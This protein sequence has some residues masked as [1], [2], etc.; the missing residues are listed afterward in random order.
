MAQGS[1]RLFL[2]SPTLNRALRGTGD[3]DAGRHRRQSDRAGERDPRMLGTCA[4]AL[5]LRQKRG[6]PVLPLRRRQAGRNARADSRRTRLTLT[7]SGNRG[8]FHPGPLVGK[9]RPARYPDWTCGPRTQSIPRRFEGGGKA[10]RAG[11][12]VAVDCVGN[13]DAP[14][15]VGRTA[16]FLRRTR[17]ACR[18]CR[19]RGARSPRRRY[20]AVK[21]ASR[22]WPAV[23]NPV[24]ADAA[25]GPLAPL[26]TGEHDAEKPTAAGDRGGVQLAART[27]PFHDQAGYRGLVPRKTVDSSTEGFTE[28][29]SFSGADAVS[30]TQSHRAGQRDSSRDVLPVAAQR[31][32]WRSRGV[33]AA[34][35]LVAI[36]RT[37]P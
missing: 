2:S 31:E 1:P 14:H 26:V 3:K 27:G 4:Q 10:N 13:R 36:K 30:E 24:C 9:S 5:V 28:N 19:G 7:G 20:P 22:L 15:S 23:G 21:E 32:G 11:R 16:P 37:I 18:G 35:S 33:G 8:C 6:R 34:P 25:V 17:T 29:R 12:R